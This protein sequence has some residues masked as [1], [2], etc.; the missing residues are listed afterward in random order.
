M[1]GIADYVFIRPLGEGNHGQYYLA[2]PPARLGLEAT[3]VVVKVVAGQTTQETFSKATR[4]LKAFAAVRS[5]YLVRLY[6]A[7][8]QAGTFFYAME[9]LERGSLAAPASELSKDAARKAVADVAR[10]AHALHEAGIVHQDIAPENVLLAEDGGRL[11]DLGLAKVLQPGVTVT[12]L[13]SR[14]IGAV[15]YVDPAMLAGGQPSRL[16]DVYSLGMTLHRALAGAGMFGDISSSAADDG[17][18]GGARRHPQARPVA[19]SGRGGADQGVHRPGSVASSAH[20]A[21]GRR[22]HRRAAGAGGQSP[23]GGRLTLKVVGLTGGIGAG[24]STVARMLASHGAVVVDSDALAREV[25]APGTPGL[26]EIVETF[27][28]GVL[29]ADGSL[30]RPGLGRIVFNDPDALRR[31]EQITHPAHPGGIGPA[32]R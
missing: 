13:G 28:P 17:D 8:Q 10:A 14:S 20:R 23:C 27:G 2:K 29:Q 26:A 21:R 19:G 9:W 16:T 1:D 5:P 32:D 30:D 31:L 4:E 18:A 7:G 15:E 11:A 3:N 6:D 22:A 12:S 24:K 25:V